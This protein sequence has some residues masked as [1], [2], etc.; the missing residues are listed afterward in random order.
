MNQN[1]EISAIEWKKREMIVNLGVIRI[2]KCGSQISRG[3]H[4]PFSDFCCILNMLPFS[5][6]TKNETSALRQ[7][8]SF[9][10]Y[11]KVSYRATKGVIKVLITSFVALTSIDLMLSDS[12]CSFSRLYTCSNLHQGGGIHGCQ[13]H[14]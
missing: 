6:E 10:S 9:K 4:F 5:Y 12:Y 3:K 2:V 13:E 14:L 11:K 8:I 1:A 7:L